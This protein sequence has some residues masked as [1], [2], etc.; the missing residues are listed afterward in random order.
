[1]SLPWMNKQLFLCLT[2]A[3]KTLCFLGL[4]IVN[5]KIR[6]GY[7]LMFYVSASNVN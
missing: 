6:K 7:R 5:W 4:H 3:I 2:A 1:M